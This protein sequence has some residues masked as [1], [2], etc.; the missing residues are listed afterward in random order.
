M[1]LIDFV[2]SKLRT[3]KT[4]S[5]KFL[6][7]RLSDD[8]LTSNMVNVRKHCSNLHHSI[9]IIFIYNCQVN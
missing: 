4:W 9:F 8:P 6:K 5:D 3:P 7:S 2:F 1:T